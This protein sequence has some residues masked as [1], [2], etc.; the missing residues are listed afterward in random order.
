[1][2]AER[3]FVDTSVLAYANQELA[4]LHAEARA[5]LAALGDTGVELWISR[6]VLREYLAVVTRPHSRGAPLPP[7]LAVERVRRFAAVFQVAE[8]SPQILGQLLDLLGTYPTGGRQV[9]DA[10]IVAT[11]LS[12]GLRRLLTF[13]VSDFQRFSS[14]IDIEPA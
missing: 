9:Y 5:Q 6:Q 14:L 10:N 3:V 1:M 7:V 11:M 8:D 4:T 2:A 13:N 12:H